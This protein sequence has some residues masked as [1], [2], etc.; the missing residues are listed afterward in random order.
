[1]FSMEAPEELEEPEY[2][3]EVIPTTRPYWSNSGPPELPELMVQ[4][5]WIIL[6]TVPSE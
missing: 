1:M 3:A 2:F 6:M 5:V 4:S